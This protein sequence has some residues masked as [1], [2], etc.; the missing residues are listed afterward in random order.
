MS[1]RRLAVVKLREG[2]PGHRPIRQGLRPSPAAPPEPDWAETFPTGGARAGVNARARRVARDFWRR[3]VA[4]LD[5]Q[6]VVSELDFAV[7]Q[8][9]AV[10]WARLD[11]A[12]RKVSRVGLTAR[13]E[14]GIT[15]NPAAVIANQT[16]EK[17]LPLLL[18]LGMSPRSREDLHVRT[19][20]SEGDDLFD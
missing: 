4:V 6:G 3:T 16:Q 11:E 9:A 15:R 17:L 12:E 14:R 19:D 20:T 10:L 13:T 7:L 2:N 18:Q 5:A 1:A 8:R